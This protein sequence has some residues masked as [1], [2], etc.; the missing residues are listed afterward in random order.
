MT[1]WKCETCGYMVETNTPP[2]ECPSCKEKCKF[3][4]NSCYT[5]DCQAEQVDKRIS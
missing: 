5:P 1:K 3:V 2:E 4:D